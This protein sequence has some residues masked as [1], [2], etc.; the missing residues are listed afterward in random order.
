MQS[1]WIGISD[2]AA[3]VLNSCLTFTPGAILCDDPN[4]FFVFPLFPCICLFSVVVVAPLCREM[5]DE[6]GRNS[7][8]NNLVGLSPLKHWS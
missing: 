6:Q 5:T 8:D 7:R 2:S 1:L 3:G 4:K